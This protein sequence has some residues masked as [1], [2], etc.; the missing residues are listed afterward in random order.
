MKEPKGQVRD[1]SFEITDDEPL[2]HLIVDE[3][4]NLTSEILAYLECLEQTTEIS[5]YSNKS[6]KNAGRALRRS[7]GDLKN[8]EKI[9]RLYRADHQKPLDTVFY[10]LKKASDNLKIAPT[11]AKRLKQ[12]DT[13]VNKLQRP[14]L[15]GSTTNSM[16]VTNMSD[17]GGC[18]FIC[19]TVTELRALQNKI[20]KLVSGISRLEILS[21]KDY[22]LEP[23]SND[24]R[25]RSIH[26][27]FSYQNRASKKFRVEAQLR[28]YKQHIWATTIE[29]VDTL[30]NTQI[31]NLSH[32]PDESKTYN[33]KQWEAL[34]KIMSDLIAFDEGFIHL[35]K[36]LYERKKTDLKM[37]ENKL[38][39]IQRLQSFNMLNDQLSENEKNNKDIEWM[40]LVV[41]LNNGKRS[42]EQKFLEDNKKKAIIIYDQ[43]EKFYSEISG[44]NVLLISVSS[45]INLSK[46]YPNYAGDC[47]QFIKLINRFL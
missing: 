3:D 12:L 15:D 39:A 6:V 21:T 40:V 25:Y 43:F 11:A 37:L 18:R 47:S 44:F 31:K 20:N 46:A 36:S 2:G 10:V 27:V 9:I 35:K 13:I 41:N 23:K 26:L 5:S 42:I 7:E 14:S 45:I 4:I 22:I 28:T 29:I 34:F 30:E 38:N 17:I 24:C 32:A 16:C 8:A 19:N 1:F 33:Q